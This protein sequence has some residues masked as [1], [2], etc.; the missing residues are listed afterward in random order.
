VGVDI[1]GDVN[2]YGELKSDVLLTKQAEADITIGQKE[3]PSDTNPS[4]NMGTYWNADK[5]N[6]TGNRM[7]CDLINA[8]KDCTE[9]V[10]LGIASDPQVK[11]D[12]YISYYKQG[13]YKGDCPLPPNG[14]SSAECLYY[15]EAV[16]FERSETSG[17][18]YYYV[19]GAWLTGNEVESSELSRLACDSSDVYPDC[20]D[21]YSV[22][23]SAASPQSALDIWGSYECV[24]WCGTIGREVYVYVQ[25]A[26]RFEKK[27]GT[28]PRQGGKL[29]AEEVNINTVSF[30]GE[31]TG[32]AN[33]YFFGYKG[34]G[35]FKQGG[36]NPPDCK[37]DSQRGTF[38]FVK[39]TN[40]G[41][42]LCY[43]RKDDPKTNIYFW[44]CW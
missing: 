13:Q 30:K 12:L 1:T 24:D 42:R 19:R 23:V 9:G 43:C 37:E 31:F 21:T 8:S 14:K 6:R 25:H 26:W 39:D 29:V 7:Q 32:L 44:H 11:Y 16:K 4:S 38:R 5:V 28:A 15:A 3:I 17:V 34:V 40:W 20:P 18:V 10:Y 27:V 22:N 33:L 2:L 35:W 41:D 36:D